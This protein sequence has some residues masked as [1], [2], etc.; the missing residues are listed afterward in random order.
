M[1]STKRVQRYEMQWS[2][3]THLLAERAA[4][5][6]GYASIK[7]FLSQLVHAKAPEILKAYSEIQL[8]NAQFDSFVELCENPKAVSPRIK[9]AAKLLD[10]EGFVLNVKKDHK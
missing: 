5:A 3:D 4:M 1:S 2:E 6:G 10:D 7:D 9:E 8:T